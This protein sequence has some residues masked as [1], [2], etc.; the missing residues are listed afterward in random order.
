MDYP[1]IRNVNVFPVQ[2]SGKTVVCLQD[3][4]NVGA[5]DSNLYCYAA[6]DPINWADITGLALDDLTDIRATVQFYDDYAANVRAPRLRAPPRGGTAC[7]VTAG[8]RFHCDAI[9]RSRPNR[10]RRIAR[11]ASSYM[12]VL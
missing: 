3:P 12:A 7:R 5:G 11:W 10:T 2:M 1:K 4:L 6:D 9:K 8:I